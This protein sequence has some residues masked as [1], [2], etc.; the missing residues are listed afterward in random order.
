VFTEIRPALVLPC[1]V[2][3]AVSSWWRRGASKFKNGECLAKGRG[4]PVTETLRWLTLRT[5]QTS[6]SCC[7]VRYLYTN[8]SNQLSPSWGLK[9]S[10]GQ[11]IPLKC[12]ICGAC[13]NLQHDTLKTGRLPKSLLPR[14]TMELSTLTVRSACTK[15]CNYKNYRKETEHLSLLQMI[16]SHSL[17]VPQYTCLLTVKE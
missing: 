3:R 1:A 13:C 9:Q 4:A 16:L 14:L 15:H 2:T 6:Q 11:Q 12:Y 7:V 8:I 10:W 17:S 5:I